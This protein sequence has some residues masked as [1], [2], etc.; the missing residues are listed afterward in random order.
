M[1]LNMGERQK[2]EILVVSAL[3]LVEL[4]IEML[5]TSYACVPLGDTLV[6]MFILFHL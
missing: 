6:A 2:Q 4:L 5:S 3:F 1:M